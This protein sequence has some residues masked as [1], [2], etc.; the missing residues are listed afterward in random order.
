MECDKLIVF[1]LCIVLISIIIIYLYQGNFLISPS[2][3][4]SRIEAFTN[5]DMNYQDIKTKTIN[6]CNKMQNVGLIN[7]EQFNECVATF[8]NNEPGLLH[9]SITTPQTGLS[10]NYSLYN[11]KTQ[12]INSTVVENSSNQ[13]NNT[14][15]VLLINNDGMTIGSKADGSLYLVNNINDDN[16]NQTDLYFTLIPN[17]DD[18]YYILS[19]YKKYL[20]ANKDYTARFTGDSIGPFAS[21]RIIKINDNNNASVLIEPVQY[22]NFHLTF[23]SDAD[24]LKFIYGRTDDMRWKLIPKAQSNT[25]NNNIVSL[26]NLY[27]ITKE[28]LLKKLYNNSLQKICINSSIATLNKLYSEI[29]NNLTSIKSHVETYLNNQQNTYNLSNADYQTRVNSL[30]KNTEL[31]DQSRTNLIAQIPPPLGLN[32]T[33]ENINNVLTKINNSMINLQNNLQNNYINQLQNKL[34]SL[35]LISNSSSG[36]TEIDLDYNNYLD[37]LNNEISNVDN[38]LKQNNI[39]ISRQRD[40]FSTT[41]DE[42]VNK[43]TKVNKLKKID[44]TANINMN[45]IGNY[46]QNNTYLNKIYPIV[47]L[48]LGLLLLYLIYITYKKFI[49]N[50]WSK[51]GN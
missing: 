50:I 26:I 40:Q 14:N 36:I 25:D 47:I 20:V 32:I 19:P 49:A 35:S 30:I 10:R 39:I 38:S 51:Y 24:T 6:W 16:I 22:N 34:S 17:T 48:I 8:K 2:I 33:T 5:G 43:D 45:L 41:N 27:Y 1:L 29:T 46:K 21:W 11:T 28:N 23:D 13:G 12:N 37:L 3:K 7:T 18:I 4:N 42:F 9:P 15:T 31:S 44:E